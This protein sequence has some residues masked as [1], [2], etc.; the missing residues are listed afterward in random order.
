MA[1]QDFAR[2]EA[3]REAGRGDGAW[4]ASAGALAF[5]IGLALGLAAGWGAA[6]ALLRGGG[7]SDAE[8]ARQA[9]RIAALEKRIAERD[10]E[11]KALKEKLARLSQPDRQVGELTFYS[12]LPAEPVT[13]APLPGEPAAPSRGA[14]GRARAAHPSP[15][16]KDMLAG[17]IQREI[18]RDDARKP[19]PAHG[20]WRVQAASFRARADAEAL[21]RRLA[22]QGFHA[23]IRDAR[24]ASGERWH[25]VMLGPW[26]TRGEAERAA[27]R[28]KAKAGLRGI[29][30]R[31]RADARR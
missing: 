23:S 3:S 6:S 26:R 16:E 21:V 27:S 1:G 17:I 5:G 19:Q 4:G 31:E 25:R 22:E 14:E 20:A 18:A 12:E 29:I 2:V 30:V 8:Q 11:I 7:A 15:Q 10:D 28:L 9:D 13:P 24:R